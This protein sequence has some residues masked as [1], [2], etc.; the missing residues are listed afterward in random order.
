MSHPSATRWQAFPALLVMAGVIGVWTC[1]VVARNEL[2]PWQWGLW[3][4]GAAALVGALWFR[5]ELTQSELDLEALHAKIEQRE[6]A[7]IEQEAA[8]EATRKVVESQLVQQAK[9][10]ETRE[11]SLAGKLTTFHE[12]MEFPQPLDLSAPLASDPEMVDLARKDRLLNE[13]LAAE[14]KR[15]FDDILAN[16]YVLEGEFQAKLVRDDALALVR[17]VAQIYQPSVEDPLLETSLAQVI[18]AA[19]RACLQ[20]LVLL[21]QLPLNVKEYSFSSLYGYVRQGVKAYGMYKSAEPFWPYVN[22]AYYIG[23]FAMGANLVTLAAWWF[24]GAWGK[25]G[26]KQ[27]ATQILQRQALTMMNSMVRVIGYEVAG[28]YG[29]DFRY[30]DPNWLY[31]VELAELVHQFPLSRESLTHAMKE[32]GALQLRH[33][34]DR[35]YL[36][37][38]IAAHASPDPERYRAGL[39]LSAEEKMAIA[40]RLERFLEAFVHGQTL[41]R[42]AK[43]RAQ[44]EGRLNVKLNVIGRAEDRSVQEQTDD[45]LRSL[46]S[47]VVAVKEREPDDLAV[48][49]PEAKLFSDLPAAERERILETLLTNPPFFF[50]QPTLDPASPIVAKYLQDLATLA[51]R[52]APH[53]TV[54][55][56]MLVDVAIYLRQ[57]AKRM[58]QLLNKQAATFLAQ[59]LPEDAPEKRFPPDV[60]RA[61]LDVLAPGEEPRFVYG[62]VSFDWPEGCQAP[63]YPK[64]QTWLVGVGDRLVIFA[65]TERPVLLWRGE[66]GLAAERVRGYLASD[67]RLHGGQWLGDARME[68]PIVRV[69]GPLIAKHDLYFKPLLAVCPLPA[70]ART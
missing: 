1:A 68:V 65:V 52:T 15:V 8:W 29:G 40:R 67:L 50:E 30:R 39:L 45:A 60:A 37:R 9:Q 63:E 31:A 48:L 23:R 46:A 16:K 62:N 34:Y 28:M 11:Q 4:G 6:R 22:T 53:E 13:L 69:A 25:E 38:C 41:E 43:W 44:V 32:I 27:L 33:E 36:Y 5:K 51:A 2:G 14:T 61:V 3:L 26:A 35:V 59:R 17:R 56:D 24:L 66:I 21:D 57:D 70:A 64:G 20:F 55:D 12:W 18:R 49:L 19:S 54:I 42:V 10:L 47:F 7:A 58:R